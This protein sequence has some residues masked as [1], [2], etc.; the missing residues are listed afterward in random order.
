VSDLWLSKPKPTSHG[1]QAEEPA[2]RRCGWWRR[3]T[4]AFERTF[5]EDDAQAEIG[6][7][8]QVIASLTAAMETLA[9]ATAA[10]RKAR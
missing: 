3:A 8:T 2:D 5:S 9:A 7:K 10:L 4:W 1:W 6:G